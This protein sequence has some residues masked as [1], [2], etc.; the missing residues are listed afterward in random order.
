MFRGDGTEIDNAAEWHLC[1]LVELMAKK[2]K[3]ALE[4]EVLQA[5]TL[6]TVE[7]ASIDLRFTFKAKREDA[8]EL[9]PAGMYFEC[10]MERI[11]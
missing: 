1:Q 11:E 5:R 2:A 10:V 6:H 7:G 9:V 4:S 8:G 3:E